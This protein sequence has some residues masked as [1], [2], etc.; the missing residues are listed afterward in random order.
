MVNSEIEVGAVIVA[1]GHSARMGSVDKIFA[2]LAGEPVILRVL[3]PFLKCE[4]IDRVVV[5]LN[6]KNY[7]DGE[8]LFGT[9]NWEKEV[10]AH[11]GGIRRQDSVLAGLKQLG[12]CDY[13]VIHDGARPLVT[14][15]LIKKGINAAKET[16]AATAAIPATDT[17]KVAGTDM[18]VQETLP[19]ENLWQIQTPQVFDY[20]LLM[21][22]YARVKQDVT[23]DAQIVELNG[24]K[25][26][27]F[28][29]SYDN[30]KITTPADLAIAEILWKRQKRK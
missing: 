10:V 5:L 22:A 24:G 6:G 17:V 9:Q 7:D 11:L 18:L 21:K 30:I 16:G 28:Q 2:P 1:A 19:R 26:K 3:E 4:L 15:D 20:D 29:G 14:V 12:D 13:V 25:V 27:L 23:D 8:E